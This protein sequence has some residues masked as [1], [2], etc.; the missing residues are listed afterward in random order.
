MASPQDS[1]S[2]YHLN[3][4]HSSGLYSK[5]PSA[6]PSWL[7]PHHPGPQYTPTHTQASPQ[8]PSLFYLSPKCLSPSNICIF[9][10]LCL[11]NLLLFLTCAPSSTRRQVSRGQKVLFCSF[12]YC[13]HLEQCLVHSRCSIN[14]GGTTGCFQTPRSSP[15]PHRH[16]LLSSSTNFVRSD[17]RGSSPAA[18]VLP[19][20]AQQGQT[21]L[22]VLTRT[23]L[24]LVFPQSSS[25]VL[26][27]R[28]CL[29]FQIKYSFL[30]LLFKIPTY[31]PH[32]VV[33][34]CDSQTPRL[35]NPK[36]FFNFPKPVPVHTKKFP[37]PGI[38]LS[39][40]PSHCPA[41]PG[42][43]VRIPS[44]EPSPTTETAF[45]PKSCLPSLSVLL[46]H[47]RTF[48]RNFTTFFF[49]VQLSGYFNFNSFFFLFK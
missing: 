45:F 44:S 32:Q 11:L 18:A 2:Q 33:P 38:S 22:L 19:A 17:P 20:T 24:L 27:S 23:R 49:V 6:H 3:T 13:H 16:G 47:L 1:D 26:T 15:A 28:A 10:F 30:T 39:C 43:K 5:V 48:L 42:P 4:R 8:L 21:R 7:S 31:V 12:L 34:P 40:P 37:L 35:A 41:R 36:S 14:I 46:T 29:G 25:E 9:L